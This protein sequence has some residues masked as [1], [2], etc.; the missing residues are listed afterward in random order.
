M[1]FLPRQRGRGSGFEQHVASILQSKGF[2][3]ITR[4]VNSTCGEIDI[5]AWRGFSKYVF[6]VKKRSTRPITV[7]DVERLWNKA[8]C[9]QGIPVLVMSHNTGIKND[10]CKHAVYL[11][12]IVKKTHYR[13]NDW[14][15]VC[16]PRFF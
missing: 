3:N 7:Y 1:Y 13:A 15:D 5:I 6:E 16:A 14:I 8:K 4:N 10:A 2:R 12:V 9:E 11:G